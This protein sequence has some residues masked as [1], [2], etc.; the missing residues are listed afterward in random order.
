MHHG[1]VA[2]FI[3]ISCCAGV[4]AIA[5]CFFTRGGSLFVTGLVVTSPHLMAR[6]NAEETTPAMFLT[7]LA[8]NGRGVFFFRVW[9]P[10]FSNRVHSRLRCNGVMSAIGIFSNSGL[11]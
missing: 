8:L 1:P 6:E 3:T 11:R 7:V 4:S 10:H 2:A 9:P 5:R